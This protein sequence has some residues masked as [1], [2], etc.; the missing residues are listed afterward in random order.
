MSVMCL[1]ACSLGGV[2]G[3]AR[4]FRGHQQLFFFLL[5][6]EQSG[7]AKLAYERGWVRLKGL[8]FE[9]VFLFLG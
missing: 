6:R 4:L 8:V 1:W 3:S 2:G 5:Y 9:G 7:G